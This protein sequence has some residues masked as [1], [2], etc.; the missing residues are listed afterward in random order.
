MGMARKRFIRLCETK[1]S[2]QKFRLLQVVKKASWRSAPPEHLLQV[3]KP[4]YGQ[5]WPENTHCPLTSIKCRAATF[6]QWTNWREWMIADGWILGRSFDL[7]DTFV[8]KFWR[9]QNTGARSR[10]AAA[11]WRL[12]SKTILVREGHGGKKERK[13]K[14]GEGQIAAQEQTLSL[15]YMNDSICFVDMQ[16]IR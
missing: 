7:W 14:N 15:Q 1:R 6:P 8:T 4:G 11:A 10:G 16:Y 5:V 9:R 3:S 2:R 12:T 13:K